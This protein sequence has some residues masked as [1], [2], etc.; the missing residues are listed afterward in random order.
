MNGVAASSVPWSTIPRTRDGDVGMKVVA[1]AEIQTGE[2]GEDDI[3]SANL[4]Q[5]ADTLE[6]RR[7]TDDDRREL[8]VLLRWMAR[9]VRNIELSSP[10][11]AP[12]SATTDALPSGE[13]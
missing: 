13:S 2:C 3:T 9:L 7:P 1:G 8:V 6:T 10:D 11:G 4:E 5:M 12:E